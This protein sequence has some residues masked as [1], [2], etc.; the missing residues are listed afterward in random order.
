MA[1]TRSG[2]RPL[3]TPLQLSPST[4]KALQETSVRS[5]CDVIEIEHYMKN[6]AH[7]PIEGIAP[8][9]AITLALTLAIGI[10]FLNG[11]QSP[12]IAEGMAKMCRAL[13]QKD[14][15]A[16]CIAL[17]SAVAT[18]GA[19][20]TARLGLWISFGSLVAS[21]A[22][23]F[24]LIIAFQQGQRAMA[25]ASAANLIAQ[26]SGQAQARAYVVIQ[27]VDCALSETGRL[28]T[29]PT[30]QNSGLSPARQLRWL[31]AAR[32][33]L[34]KAGNEQRSFML[35]LEPDLDTSHWR[36]DIP[37]SIS[38][39]ANP[40]SLRD[41]NDP[42]IAHWIAEAVFIAVTVKVVTD[43]QDVFG[44]KHREIACFQGRGKSSAAGDAF[45]PLQ[46]AP[47]EVFEQ[48]TGD[49]PRRGDPDRQRRDPGGA[50]VAARPDRARRARLSAVPPLGRGV[51]VPPHPQAL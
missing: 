7:S 50:A 8:T 1:R 4:Y 16:N 33:D 26:E 11:Q 19:V 27:S 21:S 32:L 28:T 23:F 29:R 37:S 24:G 45:V 20:M 44:L 2:I 17:R 10:V 34:T 42:E 41:Q 18:E 49:T 38:W 9:L 47:D 43:Y 30:F 13:P 25:I 14:L 46:R 12:Q 15:T 39:T 35:G 22:A 36:Q 6:N 31:Y 3:A 51:A 48:L 5:V 40:L